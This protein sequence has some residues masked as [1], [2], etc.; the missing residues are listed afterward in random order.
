M[1]PIALAQSIR[2]FTLRAACAVAILGSWT[3]TSATF[4]WDGGGA[5][6]KFSTIA[7][8]N[9]DGVVTV[10]GSDIVFG[11]LV[12]P[13]Q[14]NVEAD[15]SGNWNSCT[16]A[17]GASAMIITNTGNSM[18][19]AAATA[20]PIANNS[21]ALQTFNTSATKQFWIGGTTN[22][23][24][25]ANAGNLQ[26]NS[27]LFRPDSSVGTNLTLELTGANNGTINGTIGLEGTWTGKQAGLIKNGN[28]VWTLAGT[29]NNTYSNT[30]I[31]V[32]SLDLAKVSGAAIPGP[33]LLNGTANAKLRFAA[34]NQ[35]NNGAVL[36]FGL[37]SSTRFQLQGFNGT[38]AG[39]NDL[40][41]TGNRIVEAANDNTPGAPATLTLNPAANTTNSFSGFVR[42]AA[43]TSAGSILSLIK[44][45]NGLQI[46]SGNNSLASWSGPTTI[47]AGTLE[48]SGANGGVNTDIGMTGGTLRFSG[49]GTRAKVITGTG[50]FAKSG[51]N[52]LTLTGNNTFAGTVAVAQGTLSLTSG[53]FGLTT[54]SWNITNSSTVVIGGATV[55]H[56]NSA[57]V[58]GFYVGNGSAGTLNVTNGS[59]NVKGSTGRGLVVGFAAANGTLM[60][61]NGSNALV[62][63]DN[64]V[65]GWNTDSTLT[66][67]SGTIEANTVRHQD[68]GT[69]TF[70]LDGGTLTANSVLVQSGNGNGTLVF[71]GGVLKARLSD[72]NLLDNGTAANQLAV[73]IKN[74]GAIIDTDGKNVAALRP[75]ANFSGHTGSL[76]KLGAGTL[77][78]AAANTYSG[79]TTI[80]N[81]VLALT[82]SGAI[83]SS[84]VITVA[85]GATFD[86]SAVAFTLGASQTL[87]GNGTINGAV[88]V[89]GNVAPGASIGTLT[90]GT[91]PT[92][93]GTLT[94]EIDRAGSPNADKVVI[95]SG[96]LNFGGT[97]TVTN[98]GGALQNGDTFDLFDG[99]L[100]GAFTTI[101]LP[102]GASHWNTGDLNT[103]GALTFTNASPLAQNL[104]LGVAQ[105][106]SVSLAVI[107]GKSAPTDAD[108]D[109]MTVTG[110]SAASS[111]TSGYTA[112]S[113]TYVADGAAG[114]NTFTYTVTDALGATDTKTVTVIV[115][116]PQG[117][118][119]VSSTDLGGN[120]LALSYLG[121]PGY[122]Y[123]LD[124]ATN[125]SAPIDWRPVVTN[126]AQTNGWLNFTNTGVGMDFYRTRHV[127]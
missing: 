35:V 29:G 86:V 118:N 112:T 64:L 51:N 20:T 46:F 89:A 107:G 2:H 40:G 72:T 111:G 5:D 41:G 59:L 4:T 38:V 109:S 54:N 78:L 49:G 19:F 74:A 70:N 24:W 100:S 117:F 21:T 44:N 124:W 119:Q 45:G 126:S 97:L 36:T 66:L 6:G 85:G 95:T 1:L 77:M 113:V 62:T 65:F 53:T 90:F 58:D 71:G 92:L 116:N 79:N 47:N 28:G 76:T 84:P 43:G 123:A 27:V 127:P 22:R 48:F 17:A 25:N 98:I 8:W 55:T 11:A 82:N 105:G 34:A 93:N 60:T 42:D 12:S 67:T 18:Q 10:N 102:G 33:V 115:G 99:A 37:N 61:V 30:T 91:A 108:S 87:N 50:T 122:N 7:N 26:F 3:A 94:A 121:V 14:T 31:N 88:T 83:A 52:T 69:S 101:N 120:T 80:S 39:L 68:S 56:S 75:L 32:G 15:V 81:G 106:G 96:T 16:F 73:T 114:T 57:A 103:S 13:F 125:L 110:V 9:P 23:A 104:M 63:A